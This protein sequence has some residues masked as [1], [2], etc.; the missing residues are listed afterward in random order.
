[1]SITIEWRVI[2]LIQ[3]S[4]DGGCTHVQRKLLTNL[5]IVGWMWISYKMSGYLRLIC[6]IVSSNLAQASRLLYQQKKITKQFFC[7]I[8]ALTNRSFKWSTQFENV[9]Y[10]LIDK[11]V[12]VP[13]SKKNF[14]VLHHK[15]LGGQPTNY[16]CV[17]FDWYPW[18]IGEVCRFI[19]KKYL[20]CR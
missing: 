9:V 11:L 1:M 13:H 18:F 6:K 19:F 12:L 3:C 2:I 20:V 7:I 8:I 15:L 5:Q 17:G 10:H 14:H 16:E 4:E